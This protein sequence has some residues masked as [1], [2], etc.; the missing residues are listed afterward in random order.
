MNGPVEKTDR[1]SKSQKARSVVFY[2]EVRPLGSR[3]I[4]LHRRRQDSNVLPWMDI[5]QPETDISR[6][7]LS[8]NDVMD[9]HVHW[10]A[11]NNLP[12]YPL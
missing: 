8:C 4:E 9:G 1:D 2:D 6:Y 5:S 10:A 12:E 11:R 7:G 3:E